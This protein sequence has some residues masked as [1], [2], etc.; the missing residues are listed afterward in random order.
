[1][2]VFAPIETVPVLTVSALKL[3]LALVSESVAVPAFVRLPFETAPENVVETAVVNAR[4]APPRP[5]VPLN[6]RAP[7]PVPSPKTTSPPIE[8]PLAN[9]RAMAESEAM[10]PALSARLP[11][12]KAESLPPRSVPAASVVPPE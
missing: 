2:M 5:P 1:M 4:V 7:V 8:T 3:L 6:V 9:V 11:V 10:V 12:P